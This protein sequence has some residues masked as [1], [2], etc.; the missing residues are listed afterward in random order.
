MNKPKLIALYMIL[1]QK[2]DS[3]S[4]QNQVVEIFKVYDLA[5]DRSLKISLPQQMVSNL[6]ELGISYL[7]GFKEKFL[8][9]IVECLEQELPAS[10][11]KVEPLYLEVIFRL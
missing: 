2:T 9:K 5:I 1:D 6:S 7:K 11:N 8:D 4:I 10:E 3:L